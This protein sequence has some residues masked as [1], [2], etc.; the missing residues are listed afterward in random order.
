MYIHRRVYVCTVHTVHEPAQLCVLTSKAV[1]L[2][3]ALSAASFP[4]LMSF[5]TVQS[6]WL[7]YSAKAAVVM[8][9]A[10]LKVQYI[11]KPSIVRPGFGQGLSVERSG[12]A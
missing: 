5:L 8:E 9:K 6:I 12:A 11:R 1:G 2:K 4:L 3:L 7:I 10:I